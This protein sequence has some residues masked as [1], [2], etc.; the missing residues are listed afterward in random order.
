MINSRLF[1]ADLVKGLTA[2]LGNSVSVELDKTESA[3]AIEEEWVW[4]DG[5][6]G[7]NSEMVCRDQQY[8]IGKTYVMPEGSEI[9]ACKSGFHLCLGIIE[10]F[11][12]YSIGHGNRFFKVRALVRKSDLDKM[13]KPIDR[14]S[15]DWALESMFVMPSFK[16]VLDPNGGLSFV[17][18]GTEDK[19]SAKSIEF[20]SELTV[21]EIFEKTY[22]NKW[23]KKDKKRALIEGLRNVKQEITARELEKKKKKQEEKLVAL[24]YSRPFAVLIIDEGKYDKA[25]AV[26]TQS[27]LSMDMKVLTIFR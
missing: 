20:V 7:T 12:Y 9:E 27:D 21:D 17:A 23:S 19:L 3:S 22:A 24:G 13:A 25:Y 26:G 14:I 1:S 15:S 11:K 4:V 16:S 5:Y 18:T 10:V 6:K 2:G 8:E